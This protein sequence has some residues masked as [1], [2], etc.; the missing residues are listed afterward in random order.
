[1]SPGRNLPWMFALHSRGQG[2]SHWHS[3]LSTLLVLRTTL[4]SQLP[5]PTGNSFPFFVSWSPTH[6]DNPR[7][8]IHSVLP[9][10]STICLCSQSCGDKQPPHALSPR[11]DPIYNLHCAITFSEISFF[12]SL[13]HAKTSAINQSAE[14]LE[15]ISFP[16]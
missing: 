6:A 5:Q 2:G 3:V 8:G 16:L 13:S 12:C 1:M 9:F 4:S 7:A 10:S 15:S 14:R 11:I